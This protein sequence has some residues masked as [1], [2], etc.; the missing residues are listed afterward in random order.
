MK[1]LYQLLFVSLF[2]QVSWAER[3]VEIAPN[4]SIAVG[5]NLKQ[6]QDVEVK[7]ANLVASNKFD[8]S[9]VKSV[10]KNDPFLRPV[11][12]RSGVSKYK[13]ETP[14]KFV[15]GGSFTINVELRHSGTFSGPKAKEIRDSFSEYLEVLRATIAR[16]DQKLRVESREK[17][18]EAESPYPQ[19]LHVY[20]RPR[21][22]NKKLQSA[23]DQL[24]RDSDGLPGGT[25]GALL[26]EVWSNGKLT[27]LIK[28]KDRAKQ[29]RDYVKSHELSEE[30][31]K[32]TNLIINDL[33]FAIREVEY[34]NVMAIAPL[35]ELNDRELDKDEANAEVQT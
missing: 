1:Y 6:M 12:V 19:G 4:F 5:P 26:D 31:R 32:I 21:T 22:N 30:D 10:L 25:A 9:D 13:L 2:I 3:T 18:L 20:A 8:C 7:V 28:A 23:Y 29:L 24:F 35:E 17:S 27:H 34:R 15:Q 16:E 11:G 14:L 33:W